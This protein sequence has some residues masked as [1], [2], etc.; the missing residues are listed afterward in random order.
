[1]NNKAQTILGILVV[2]GLGY[3]AYTKYYKKPSETP[4]STMN[5]DGQT[6]IE[7]TKKECPPGT[8]LTQVQC[9]MAPCEPMCVDAG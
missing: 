4:A 8:K 7:T 5:D 9:I 6:P 3:W 1:M 2:A